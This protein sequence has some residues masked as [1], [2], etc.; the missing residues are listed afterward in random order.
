M[1]HVKHR[2]ERK[3]EM[4]KVGMDMTVNISVKKNNGEV[5]CE[6]IILEKEDWKFWDPATAWQGYFQK[7]WEEYKT[8]LYG[9]WLTDWEEVKIICLDEVELA[10]DIVVGRLFNGETEWELNVPYSIEN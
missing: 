6:T 3:I 10:L 2:K 5:L 9:D 8:F 1:F 4:K 7:V